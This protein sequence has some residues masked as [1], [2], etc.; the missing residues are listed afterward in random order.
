LPERANALKLSDGYSLGFTC[1]QDLQSMVDSGTDL[2][3]T[4]VTF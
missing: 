4:S 3:C 2:F 1:L